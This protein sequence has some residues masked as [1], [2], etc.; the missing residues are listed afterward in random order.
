MTEHRAFTLLRQYDQMK[1]ELFLLEQELNRE[2]INYARSKG[3]AFLY[4]HH[5]RS[6]ARL[7]TTNQ[8]GANQ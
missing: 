1:S 8:E 5:L 3:Y 6:I 4:P 7:T 2:C